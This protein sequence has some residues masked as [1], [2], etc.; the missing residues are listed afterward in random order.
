MSVWEHLKVAF[1]H[2]ESLVGPHGA[3]LAGTNGD[4]SDFSARYLH[5]TESML[6]PAQLAYAYPRLAALADLRGDRSFAAQLR[7]RARA[8][9]TLLRRTWTGRWYLRGYSGST[10]IGSGAIFGEP[11]PWAVLAG[12]PNAHQ[13]GVARPQHPP[14]PD[15]D[16]RAAAGARTSPD[17]LGDHPSVA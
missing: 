8:L 15:R 3:Y 7:R 9:V 2:Q 14:L 11:Q 16:R 4:W 12:A 6:V 5:M 13:A 17:R 10:P 1:R